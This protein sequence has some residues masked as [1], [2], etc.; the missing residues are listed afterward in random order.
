MRR[1]G[2]D[3]MD[4]SYIYDVAMYCRLS[5]GVSRVDLSCRGISAFLRGGDMMVKPGQLWANK[6]V[7]YLIEILSI[8]Y[9][10]VVIANMGDWEAN[11]S[12]QDIY[13]GFEYVGEL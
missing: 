9:G 5:S 2:N 10:F 11:W 3:G 6:Y 8:Q 1:R 12:I 7:G 4:R 13:V